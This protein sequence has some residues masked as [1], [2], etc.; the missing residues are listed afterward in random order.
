[1]FA[2]AGATLVTKCDGHTTRKPFDIWPSCEIE[3]RSSR[4]PLEVRMQSPEV[5]PTPS[6][7]VFIPP[8]S[9][10]GASARNTLFG[11]KS[12]PTLP[13]ATVPVEPLQRPRWPAFVF[14]LALLLTVLWSGTL[15]WLTYRTGRL[16]LSALI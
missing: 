11:E 8:D 9:L 2:F 12:V 16:L 15:L 10:S 3:L 13:V 6:A 14:A 7:R 4:R 1:M 5:T